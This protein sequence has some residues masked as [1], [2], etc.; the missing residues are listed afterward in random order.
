V[1]FKD[2][3]K[4]GLMPKHQIKKEPQTKRLIRS[5]G[6]RSTRSKEKRMTDKRRLTV[7]D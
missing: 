4:K 6:R 5:T 3:L 1:H 2:R 7:N